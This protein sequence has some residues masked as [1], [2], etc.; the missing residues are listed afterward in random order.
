MTFVFKEINVWMVTT[1]GVVSKTA[2]L[3]PIWFEVEWVDANL[4]ELYNF[5]EIKAKYGWVVILGC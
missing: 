5:I 4:I 3:M 1:W 2:T